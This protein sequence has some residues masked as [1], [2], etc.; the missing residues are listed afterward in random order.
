MSLLPQHAARFQIMSDL[1]LELGQQ[2][3]SLYIPLRL[4]IS[5]LLA[6]L[7][8]CRLSLVL[9]F[10]SFIMRAIRTTSDSIG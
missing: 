10:S 8:V 5:Y 1:H 3:T 2:Y 6:I 4:L 9:D 7:G